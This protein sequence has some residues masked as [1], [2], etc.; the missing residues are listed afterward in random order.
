MG[1]R[2]A[3]VRCECGRHFGSSL[4]NIINC[5]RCNSSKNLKILKRYSSSKSLKQDVSMSNTPAEIADEISSR[6]E[7]YDKPPKKSDNLNKEL[8]EKIL[9]SSTKPDGTITMK[10]ISNSITTHR[11]SK[12]TP[13]EVIEILEKSSVVLR[14]SDGTWTVLQ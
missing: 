7:T 6:L 8:I 9:E 3:M 14:N 2:W 13:D 5:P 11:I 12:I 10:S 1:E 4:K